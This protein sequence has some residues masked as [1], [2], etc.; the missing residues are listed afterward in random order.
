MDERSNA[1][2]IDSAIAS[3]NGDIRHIRVLIRRL[4]RIAWILAATA[5]VTAGGVIVL[6]VGR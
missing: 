1:A 3:L 5:G 4:E 2:Y 6:L